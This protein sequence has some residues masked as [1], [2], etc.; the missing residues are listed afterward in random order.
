MEDCIIEVSCRIF[1]PG[2]KKS[3]SQFKEDPSDLSDPTCF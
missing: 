1:G 3:Y 2:Q